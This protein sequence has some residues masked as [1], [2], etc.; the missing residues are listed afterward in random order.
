[1]WLRVK[2]GLPS[3]EYMYRKPNILCKYAAVVLGEEGIFQRGGGERGIYL[4]VSKLSV[5]FNKNKV[6]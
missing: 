1:M 3:I 4:S 5:Y 2:F 6:I